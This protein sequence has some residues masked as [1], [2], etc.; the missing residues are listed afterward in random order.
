[1]TETL[2]FAGSNAWV[3][4]ADA[5][6]DQVNISVSGSSSTVLLAIDA[7]SPSTGVEIPRDSNGRGLV[8]VVNPNAD[9]WLFLQSGVTADII[10]GDT[11]LFITQ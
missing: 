11:A 4:V 3:K 9:V 5:T 2:Q 7:S 6:F 10:R 1:M 8:R